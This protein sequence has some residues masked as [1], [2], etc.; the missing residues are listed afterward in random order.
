MHHTY[1]QFETEIGFFLCTASVLRPFHASHIL[2]VWNWNCFFSFY[3]FFYCNSI[4][5]SLPATEINCLEDPKTML[6]GQF[7]G[8]ERENM[9]HYCSRATLATHFRM[10][11]PHSCN[12]GLLSLWQHTA[13]LPFLISWL[14]PLVPALLLTDIQLHKLWYSCWKF[15]RQK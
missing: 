2:P 12:T 9:C 10:N 15:L 5:A 6:P 4:F 14:L 13:S 8:D 3:S 11:R 7:W 1:C